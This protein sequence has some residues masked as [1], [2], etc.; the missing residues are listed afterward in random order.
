MKPNVYTHTTFR[1]KDDKQVVYEVVNIDYNY[2]GLTLY[3]TM[4]ADLKKKKINTYNY[5][6]DS[7]IDKVYISDKN[8]T[9]L[10]ENYRKI[11]D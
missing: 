7:Y 1:Y 4:V 8:L 6:E 9:K 5:S 2:D 3:K 11:A 10:K